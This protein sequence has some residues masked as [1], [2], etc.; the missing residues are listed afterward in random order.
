MT[1]I[2]RTTKAVV[3]RAFIGDLLVAMAK[4]AVAIFSGSAAILA[5]AI[6]SSSDAVNQFLL[7]FGYNLS[8]KKDV[9]KF[10]FGRGR[11]Q[12][13]W[14]FVAALLV[15]SVSG[16]LSV[17]EGFIKLRTNYVIADPVAAYAVL[18]FS[19]ALDGYVLFISL[20]SFF[21]RFRTQGYSDL[22][23]FIRDFRDPVLLTAIVEDVGA[24]IGVVIAFVGISLSIL[25]NNKDFDAVSSILIGVVMMSSGIYLAKESK[26]LLIGEGISSRDQKKIEL[27]LASNDSI[28]KVLDLRTVYQSPESALLAMDLNFKDGLSTDEIENSIDAIEKEIRKA[29]PSISRIYVEAEEKKE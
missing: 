10:P 26:D 14:A 24:T 18:I 27:I 1:E 22:R 15:F 19:F 8:S 12:F 3:L 7:L 6:H 17:V 28:N 5:E 2:V 23:S 9:T 21:H 16:I 29:V 13:F 11:E 25:T 4:Y 20:G